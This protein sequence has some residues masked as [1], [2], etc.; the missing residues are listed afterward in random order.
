MRPI[1][2]IALALLL[3]TAA[4][5]ATDPPARVDVAGLRDVTAEALRHRQDRL[6][7]VERFAELAARPATVILDTR[8]AAAYRRLHVAGAV[9]LPFSDFTAP[10]LAKLLPDPDTTIL[11]YCNNNI[12]GDEP[13]FPMKREPLALNLPT[14]INLYGYGYRA[15]WELDRSI[16]VDD[17]RIAFAGSDVA[18]EDPT[19]TNRRAD[20]I[21]GTTDQ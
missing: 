21:I 6:V 4:V 16:A 13:A 11:I 10:K 9:N 15:V 18:G 3:S 12:L 7:D 2:T 20:P 17:P 8:S 14:F 5:A 19:H 1:R